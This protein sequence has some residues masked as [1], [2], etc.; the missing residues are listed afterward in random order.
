MSKILTLYDFASKQEYIYRT[1]KIKEIAGASKLLADMYKVFADIF[2]NGKKTN[3][4]DCLK[5]ELETK[6]KTIFIL[7]KVQK[8]RR[9]R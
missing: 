7:W 6:N 9:I 4:N 5:K 1:S 8:K 3:G 2:R